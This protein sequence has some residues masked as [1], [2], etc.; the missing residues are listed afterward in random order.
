MIRDERV[1]AR[2]MSF[3]LMLEMTEGKQQSVTIDSSI[4]SSIL[5][6]NSKQIAN[7]SVITAFHNISI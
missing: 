3:L 6:S 2:Y 4:A 5:I 1:G 7:S